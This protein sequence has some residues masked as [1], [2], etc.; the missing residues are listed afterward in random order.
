MTEVAY[1]M[2][3]YPFVSVTVAVA[4]M[5]VEVFSTSVMALPPFK[6]TFDTVGATL[7]PVLD[8]VCAAGYTV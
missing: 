7:P 2:F 8:A 6:T 5:E 3:E 4:E 1:E